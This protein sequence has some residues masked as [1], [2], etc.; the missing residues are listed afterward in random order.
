MVFFRVMITGSL[1]SNCRWHVVLD[2]GPQVPRRVGLRLT[3]GL[4]GTGSGQD[5]PRTSTSRVGTGSRPTSAWMR[6]CAS[7]SPPAHGAGICH[8][9]PPRAAARRGQAS[10]GWTDVE[11]LAG[12][13]RKLPGRGPSAKNDGDLGDA[14]CRALWRADRRGTPAQRRVST[15]SDRREGFGGVESSGHVSS[16]SSRAIAAHC[17]PPAY[18]REPCRWPGSR[19]GAPG[20]HLSSPPVPRAA[21]WT[22]SMAVR[23][24]S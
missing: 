4:P 3:L 23:A 5:L 7:G 12:R 22:G 11:I 6:S 8:V 21:K 14:L 1:Q 2:W 10:S 17:Q 20:E 19:A 18:A 15:K 16:G 9:A 13:N 24:I